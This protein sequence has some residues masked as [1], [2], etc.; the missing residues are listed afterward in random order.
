MRL[1]SDSLGASAREER[2]ARQS[3][4]RGVGLRSHAVDEINPP[5]RLADIGAV[6]IMVL[7][8]AVMVFVALDELTR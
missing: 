1:A 8:L 4:A 3:A 2:G 6:L 7:V 5:S